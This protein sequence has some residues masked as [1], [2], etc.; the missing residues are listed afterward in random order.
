MVSGEEI[1]NIYTLFTF[2]HLLV[3]TF[4]IVHLSAIIVIRFFV[5]ELWNLKHQ[6]KI[7]M[8]K[9]HLFIYPWRF[10]DWHNIHMLHCV[11]LSILGTDR[12][13]EVETSLTVQHCPY[14][15]HQCYTKAVLIWSKFSCLRG[16]GGK[17]NQQP[18][19]WFKSLKII[20]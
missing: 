11:L 6:N 15:R 1:S 9:V 7:N 19:S 4:N 12:H 16:T 8:T 20:I 18:E 17:T 13:R 2:V 5:S 3:Y 14:R 10:W